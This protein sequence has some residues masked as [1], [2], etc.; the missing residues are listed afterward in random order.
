MTPR[1]RSF[2]AK[3]VV[4]LGKLMAASTVFK[5]FFQKEVDV[6]TLVFGVIASV[7]AFVVAF[8]LEPSA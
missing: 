8:F 7:I 4:D 3:I 6:G 1:R 5:Q 2:L